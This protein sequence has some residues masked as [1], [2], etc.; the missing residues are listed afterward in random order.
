[1]WPGIVAEYIIGPFRI[2]MKY[3]RA[4]F[5][6]LIMWFSK[7][8]SFCENV[9]V[10]AEIEAFKQ[11]FAAYKHQNVTSVIQTDFW[12][13]KVLQEVLKQCLQVTNTKMAL[14]DSDSLKCHQVKTD[15]SSLDS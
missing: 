7:S 13:W 5:N 1:M 15:F 4:N 12:V 2:A 3:C 10:P 9:V 14:V 8:T 11:F 6:K